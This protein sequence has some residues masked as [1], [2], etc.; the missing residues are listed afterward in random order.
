VQLATLVN[1][2]RSLGLDEQSGFA[3]AVLLLQHPDTDVNART[4]PYNP[5]VLDEFWIFLR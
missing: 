1:H 2:N 5:S 4:S 3:T